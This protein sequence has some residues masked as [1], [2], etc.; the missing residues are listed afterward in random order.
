MESGCDRVLERIGKGVTREVHV[1]AGLKVKDAGMELSVYYMP[2]LRGRD[3]YR[4]NAAETAE[5]LR[6]INVHFVRLR[7]WPSPTARPSP[8]RPAPGGSPGADELALFDQALR[9]ALALE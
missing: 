6:R 4:E 7:P 9:V 3:L 5:A 8:R 2:G 1:R